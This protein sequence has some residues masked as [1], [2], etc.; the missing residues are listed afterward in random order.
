MQRASFT[1]T[2]KLGANRV[3]IIYDANHISISNR[4]DN[5]GKAGSVVN[6][7]CSGSM[8]SLWAEEIEGIVFHPTGAYHCGEC[9][10]SIANVVGFG[11]HANAAK[12]G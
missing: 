9:D 8:K 6:F 1:I 11:I 12:D 10:Q 2:T 3:A 4:V 5:D 7:I